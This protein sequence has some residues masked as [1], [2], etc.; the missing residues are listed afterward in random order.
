MCKM[1][2]QKMT[3]KCYMLALVHTDAQVHA[4]LCRVLPFLEEVLFGFNKE[5]LHCKR[6]PS[7]R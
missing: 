5:L 2:A 6:K 3:E 4:N 1:I 7:Q